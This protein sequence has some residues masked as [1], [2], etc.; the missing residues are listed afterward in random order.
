MVRGDLPPPGDGG[1]PREA[2]ARCLV[3]AQVALVEWWLTESPQ[4]TPEQVDEIFRALW[5][6]GIGTACA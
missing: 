1:I 4:S 5:R 2:V 6:P 3:A